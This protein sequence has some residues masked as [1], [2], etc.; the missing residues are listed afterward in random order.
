MSRA[1]MAKK[2][3]TDKQIADASIAYWEHYESVM[4]ST[5]EYTEATRAWGRK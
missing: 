5:A 3:P 2:A 1:A 4:S